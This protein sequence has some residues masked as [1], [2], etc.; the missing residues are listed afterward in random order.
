[1]PTRSF[2]VPFGMDE[3]GPATASVSAAT[4]PAS[5]GGGIGHGASWSRPSR[6]VRPA[7]PD[8]GSE[9]EPAGASGCTGAWRGRRWAW[10]RRG[11]G[12]AARTRRHPAGVMRV[13][14]DRVGHH[15]H[16][17]GRGA[18]PPA[19]GA[20]G[21]HRETLSPGYAGVDSSFPRHAEHGVDTGAILVELGRRRRVRGQGAMIVDVALDCAAGAGKVGGK[22]RLDLGTASHGLGRSCRR[23]GDPRSRRWA[24]RQG[25]ARAVRAISFLRRGARRHLG[26]AV[27]RAAPR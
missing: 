5:G 27:T 8:L 6:G 2:A 14:R 11:P 17:R 21:A 12:D 25:R 9:A 19:P 13:A 24:M 1:M 10:G 26:R 18:G 4:A 16:G 7:R 22:T 20:T 3:R 15:R 23:Q